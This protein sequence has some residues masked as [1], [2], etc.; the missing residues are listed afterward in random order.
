MV[1]TASNRY[2]GQLDEI[3]EHFHSHFGERVS[4]PPFD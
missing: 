1:K 3:S 2:H 4:L